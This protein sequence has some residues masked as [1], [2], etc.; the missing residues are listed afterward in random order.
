MIPP[1]GKLGKRKAANRKI[2]LGKASAKKPDATL[3]DVKEEEEK[4]DQDRDPNEDDDEDKDPEEKK[5]ETPLGKIDPYLLKIDKLD[6]LEDFL[7]EPIPEEDIPEDEDEDLD[8]EDG[9][10]DEDDENND[11]DDDFV[12]PD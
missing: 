5:A 11:D 7:E 3:E 1:L 9:Q 2:L 6:V 4:K 8:D 12:D 10:R